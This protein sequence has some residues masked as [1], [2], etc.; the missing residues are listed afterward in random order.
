MNKA[1]GPDGES[2]RAVRVA[3]LA[4]LP[5]NYWIVVVSTMVNLTPVTA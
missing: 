4:S 3:G 1:N 5:T 2:I